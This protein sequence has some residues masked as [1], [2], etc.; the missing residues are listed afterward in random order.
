MAIPGLKLVQDKV[1]G[2]WTCNIPIAPQFWSL[3]S[4]SVAVDGASIQDV[5]ALSFYAQ[6]FVDD[7]QPQATANTNLHCPNMQ[8]HFSYAADPNIQLPIWHLQFA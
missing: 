1:I 5:T 7:T 4:Q 6:F 8:L 2:F 3:I